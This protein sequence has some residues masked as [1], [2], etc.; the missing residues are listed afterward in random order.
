MNERLGS[1]AGPE[2]SVLVVGGGFAALGAAWAAVGAGAQVAWISGGIGASA[3][4]CGI[5]DGEPPGPE[6]EELARAL[7]LRVHE[8]P[9]VVATREGVV[10]AA[11]GRDSALLDLESL[12]GRCIGVVDLGRDDWDA[13]L[14]AQSLQESA[15]ARRT[16]SRFVVQRVPALASGAERRISGYDLAQAYDSTERVRA[17]VALLRKVAT[18]V[19]GWLFGPWL[20]IV[21]DAARFASEELGLP[22]G[23]VSSP[24]GGA[25]GARFEHKSRALLSSLGVVSAGERA[26]RVRR[27]GAGG[28][29]EKPMLQVELESSEVLRARSVV[30]AIGGVLGGGILLGRVEAD[31]TRPWQ[32]SLDAPVTLELDGEVMDSASSLSGVSFERLGLGVLERIGVRAEPGLRLTP[33]LPLYGAGELLAGRPRNVLQA[34]SSGIQA[35]RSAARDALS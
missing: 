13:D 10:R 22:I 30:L 29:A 34:L 1:G 31:L 9:R 21:T 4:Y 35:G 7:G 16:D 14:V 8:H 2:L 11:A 20:G 23:E 26:L 5:V 25:A 6:T 3:L 27:S 17:L 19:D 18:P 28:S 24:P 12:A 32:L 33:E 15:W